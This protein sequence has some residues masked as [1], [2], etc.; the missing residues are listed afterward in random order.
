MNNQSGTAA[1]DRLVTR[2]NLLRG[3][4]VGAAAVVAL[5]LPRL[6]DAAG[7]TQ[8]VLDVVADPGQLDIVPSGFAGQGPFYIPGEIFEA[9]TATKIGDFHCWGFFIQNGAVGVVSQEY[10]LTGRG[11]IQVQGVEDEG[12]RAVTGGTGEFRNTRG[13]MT[14]ADLSAFPAFTV[15]F[16]L[17]G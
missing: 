4:A 8:L 9:G 13:E 12:P 15:N 5:G 2:R 3:G 17:I 7:G 1:F 10:D 14:G 6:A 11:K 16:S